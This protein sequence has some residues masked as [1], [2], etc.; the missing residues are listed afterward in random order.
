[1][2]TDDSIQIRCPKCKSKFRDRARRVQSGY[3]RE[4]PSCERVIFFEAGSPNSDVREALHQAER[5]RRLL[6]QDEL[7][8][9]HR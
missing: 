3:S 5:V 2:S 9:P 1:M 4:C 6:R 7:A 8:P